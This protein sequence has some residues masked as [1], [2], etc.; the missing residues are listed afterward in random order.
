MEVTI[1][2]SRNKQTLQNPILFNF[3]NETFTQSKAKK[4][5]ANGILFV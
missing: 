1:T 3:D 5:Q 2:T 4:T